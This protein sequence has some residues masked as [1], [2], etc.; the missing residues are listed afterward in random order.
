MTPK[1]RTTKRTR[2]P[3]N[4]TER[5]PLH[6]AC[7]IERKNNMKSEHTKTMTDE[8]RRELQQEVAGMDDDALAEFRNCFDEDEMGFY[9]EEGAIE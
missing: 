2:T 5:K 8:E 6:G 9:G 3:L 4:N 7:A 1:K